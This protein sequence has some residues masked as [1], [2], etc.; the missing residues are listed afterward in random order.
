M[1]IITVA[2]DTGNGGGFSAAQGAINPTI[3]GGTC[4]VTNMTTRFMISDFFDS[5]FA[6]LEDPSLKA[7]TTS[8]TP[9]SFKFNA[10]A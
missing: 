10:C 9:L 6:L 4:I 3:S 1:A 8:L 2:A 7:T 5:A